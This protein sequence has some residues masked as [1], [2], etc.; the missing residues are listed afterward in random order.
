MSLSRWR[1]RSSFGLNDL[2]TLV[3]LACEGTEWI[4]A[5][6]PHTLRES[7]G[8]LLPSEGFLCCAKFVLKICTMDRMLQHQW[9]G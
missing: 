8:G 9:N 1:K 6:P 5:P 7:L 3:N 2:E 4:S